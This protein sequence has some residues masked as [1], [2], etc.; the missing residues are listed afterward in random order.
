MV[1]F[2]F[3]DSGLLLP[4]HFVYC[5]DKNIAKFM[6]GSLNTSTIARRLL[7]YCTK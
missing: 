4:W 1:G 5:L 6:S 2:K 3:N 7:K